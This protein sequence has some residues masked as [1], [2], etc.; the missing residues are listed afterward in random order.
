MLAGNS[1]RQRP[2][3]IS[4][5]STHTPVP[6]RYP[7]RRGN[8]GRQAAHHP[9]GHKAALRLRAA[10]ANRRADGDPR[11]LGQQAIGGVRPRG[12]G[13]QRAQIAAHLRQQ[14]QNRGGRRLKNLA[15]LARLDPKLLYP[16]RHRGEGSQ[17]HMAMIRSR[18]ALIGCRTQLVN[19]VPKEQS[20]PSGPACPISAPQGPSTRGRPSTSR[21]RF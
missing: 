19:H 6:H 14:A 7:E 1:L 2:D 20:S 11:A 5:T 18:Q 8:R 9:R 17:A 12:A 4:A 16:V 15:R 3:W 13:G 21:R 10:A